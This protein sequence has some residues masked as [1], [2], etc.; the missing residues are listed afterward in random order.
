VQVKLPNPEN[1]RLR[2][3][4]DTYEKQMTTYELLL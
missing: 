1:A 3:L 4:I 2:S